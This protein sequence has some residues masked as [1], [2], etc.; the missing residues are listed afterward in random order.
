MWWW[1]QY[2]ETLVLPFSAGEVLAKLQ[3]VTREVAVAAEEKPDKKFL[4]NGKISPGGFSISRMIHSPDNSL[5]L[6]NARI[7]STSTG[8]IVFLRFQLFFGARIFL[9][10]WSM[11]AVLLFSLFVFSGPR[12]IPAIASLLAGV[13]N[14]VVNVTNFER[15]VSVSKQVLYKVLQSA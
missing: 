7:E 8:C 10:F 4:F 14:Y 2:T 1:P 12:W 3:E 11:V 15:R 6:I 9:V 13:I 5:P